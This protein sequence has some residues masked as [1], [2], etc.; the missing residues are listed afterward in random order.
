MPGTY[1]VS[2]HINKDTLEEQNITWY[3]PE[4]DPDGSV[5]CLSP[6]VIHSFGLKDKIEKKIHW[7]HQEQCMDISSLSGMDVRG[8]LGTSSLYVNMPQAY[9]QYTAANWDPPSR[10]D[11]G[12]N[13]IL[14]DY[15]LSGQSSR[16]QGEGTSNRMSGN[17]TLGM[18][19]GAW[20]LRADWQGE[21]GTGSRYNNQNSFDWSRYYAFRP[22]PSLGA[23][24]TIGETSFYSDLFDSFSFTGASL[25]S[26]D[27]MLPP[28]LRGYA[29]EI[30]GVAKTN[31]R[32]IISMQ[33]R[34]LKETQVAAGPFR[35]QDL[36]DVV[37]GELD[38]RVEEQDGTVQHFKVNTANVPYLTRPGSVRYKFATGRA[39]EAHRP[40][41][42]LFASGEFSWGVSNGWSLY[43]GGI[44]GEDY[45]ALSA[46]IG[47]DLLFLGALSLDTTASKATLPGENKAR[48]GSSYR[49][50]YS[51]RFESTGSQVTFAGY[52]FSTHDFISMGEYLDTLNYGRH[53]GRS[54]EMYTVTLDQQIEDLGIGLYLNYNH[55]SFWDQKP[56]DRYTLSFNK[57]FD[58]GNW[59]NINL[60]ASM[61]RNLYQGVKDN[62]MY[63]NLSVPV[64]RGGSLSY[65]GTFSHGSGSHRVDYSG[66]RD[67]GDYYRLG[68]GY[69]EDSPTFDAGY[70]HNTR[71]ARM[72][73]NLS[74][75]PEGYSYL[76]MTLNGGVT[77]TAEGAALHNGSNQGGTRMLLDTDGV[78]DIPI[79]QASNRTW[80]NKFG[81]AVV[82][83]LGSYYRNRINIDLNALPDNAEVSNSVVQGT[84][85]E[86]AIGYRKFQVVSGEKTMASVR[87]ADGTFPPLGASVTN[88]KHQIAGVVND[89]GS[90][91]LS[92]IHSGEI[93]SVEWDGQEQ[94]QITLP[95]DKQDLSQGLLL[96]CAAQHKS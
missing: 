67:N 35:I 55:E 14:L 13:G 58:I 61:Y 90:V 34:V 64:G 76:N 59:R 21:L 41:G 94:C 38:V 15:Y 93:M 44:A 46:G 79:G 36:N 18:N 17:G 32:V 92:G 69:S 7:T 45:N 20:R 74:W 50:S 29:P 95:T 5:P 16:S 37:S 66:S 96:P 49:M 54:K 11:T 70:T 82:T 78:P 89:D 51:K 27:N 8:D 73:S 43:G 40:A 24:L 57:N 9:L 3:A 22:L 83:S 84:L 10:W 47:R 88:A 81:K 39:S 31:A 86:G 60:S 19:L 42:P 71:Y 25:L 23:R 65:G 1:P 77:A 72:N 56:D 68:T 63:L 26:D 2:I 87:L 12:I 53:Y 6:D 85:T 4:N 33:S 30:T 91:Y 28:N 52:R 62:G 48:S 75:N 80:S